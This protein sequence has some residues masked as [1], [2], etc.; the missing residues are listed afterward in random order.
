[1]NGA[2]E[3]SIDNAARWALACSQWRLADPRCSR[4]SITQRLLLHKLSET[5]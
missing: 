2:A 4:V 3:P 5:D 1:M